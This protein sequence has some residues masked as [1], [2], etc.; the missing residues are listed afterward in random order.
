MYSL[1]SNVQAKI[2]YPT[3]YS[4]ASFIF[5]HLSYRQTLQ[6][7]E[8]LPT[9]NIPMAENGKH[10][11]FISVNL[12]QNTIVS[13][14]FLVNEILK[15]RL[16]YSRTIMQ[17][18]LSF[19]PYHRLNSKGKKRRWNSYNRGDMMIIQSQKMISPSRQDFPAKKVQ[20]RTSYSLCRNSSRYQVQVASPFVTSEISRFGSLALHPLPRPSLR[21]VVT[22]RSPNSPLLIIC[23]SL[24]SKKVFHLHTKVISEVCTWSICWVSWIK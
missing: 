16:L 20:A 4:I 8:L 18:K 9:A 17:P 1:N 24:P 22:G 5:H 21:L 23:S 15:F 19:L 13:A 2:R 10:N 6:H 12:T 7:H 3:Q 11:W 14:P